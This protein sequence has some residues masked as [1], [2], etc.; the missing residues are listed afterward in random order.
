MFFIKC[1][2]NSYRENLCGKPKFS[3]EPQGLFLHMPLWIKNNFSTGNF[4]KNKDSFFH[5]V[6]LLFPQG[7]VEKYQRLELIFAV[8][9]RILF[10]KEE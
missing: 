6:F 4:E 10:C 8:I 3:L 7:N 2:I 9:S 5:R 1:S